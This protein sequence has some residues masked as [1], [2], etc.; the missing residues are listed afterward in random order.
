VKALAAEL[1]EKFGLP[2]EFVAM[3]NPL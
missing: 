1:G 2:W 3:E